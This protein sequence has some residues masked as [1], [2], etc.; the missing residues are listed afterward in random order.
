MKLE[1][2]PQSECSCQKCTN[3]CLDTP[4]FATPED[5]IKLIEAKYGDRLMMDYISLPDDKDIEIITPAR[6]GWEQTDGRGY[7][8]ND[9]PCTFLNKE[10]LCELHY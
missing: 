5:V 3:M 4:C 8:I 7:Y 9:G 10:K 6:K 2:Y 1:D